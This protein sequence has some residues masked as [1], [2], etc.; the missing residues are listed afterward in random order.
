M[1]LENG[2]E[3]KTSTGDVVSRRASIIRRWDQLLLDLTHDSGD[4]R[5]STTSDPAPSEFEP[6]HTTTVTPTP[7]KSSPPSANMQPPLNEPVHQPEAEKEERAPQD[8]EGD[9]EVTDLLV[10]DDTTAMVNLDPGAADSPQAAPV[11]EEEEENIE[12][13]HEPKGEIPG[14]EL[15]YD[16][17]EWT[18]GV[19]LE[20]RGCK[21]LGLQ[22]PKCA[23]GD[24]DE[25]VLL[26]R[27]RNNRAC[28]YYPVWWKRSP[29]GRSARRGDGTLVEKQQRNRPGTDWYLW[30]VT[31]S[32]TDWTIK[33]R[34]VKVRADLT[35]DR[36]TD[37][38]VQK[39]NVRKQM[40]PVGR[41][42]R[43]SSRTPT[44]AS[45]KSKMRRK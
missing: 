28:Q 1:K 43:R 8:G 22:R 38:E 42:R 19:L 29:E 20:D 33:R 45:W 4:S 15:H 44:P 10:K 16:V 36:A 37:E 27:G 2:K 31:P 34:G 24:N 17:K 6:A 3:R 39:E 32:E 23:Q 9:H 40:L 18:E 30:T 7:N 12:A 41:K 35:V 11:P 5:P 14:E 25:V 26:A 21:Y 13:D